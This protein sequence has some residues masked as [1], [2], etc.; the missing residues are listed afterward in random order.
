MDVVNLN[1]ARMY[2]AFKNFLHHR[3]QCAI[4]AHFDLL[5]H[6]FSTNLWNTI[7]I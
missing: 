4:S 6:V 1:L 3:T 2:L 5:V 7:Y